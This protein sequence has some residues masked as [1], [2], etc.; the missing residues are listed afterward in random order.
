MPASAHGVRSSLSLPLHGDGKVVGALNIYAMRPRAFGEQ[1][2]LTA[3]W[4]AAEASLAL[5]P[6]VRMAERTEMS[7][8]LQSAL[9][10]RAVIDQALGV[11]MGQN[12]CTADEAFDI[13]R[14]NSQNR[15]VKLRDVAV[16]VARNKYIAKISDAGH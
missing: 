9:A 6:A 1:E 11:V 5:A 10:S 2:Q 13:L 3:G 12:R 14:M 4:F 15:N 7:E 16:A 8:H